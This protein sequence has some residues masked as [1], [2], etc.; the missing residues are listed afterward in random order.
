MTKCYFENPKQKC[1]GEIKTVMVC[2]DTVVGYCEGH[3]EFEDAETVR[4]KIEYTALRDSKGEY[5]R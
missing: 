4:Y 1:W 5:K 3:N 2:P